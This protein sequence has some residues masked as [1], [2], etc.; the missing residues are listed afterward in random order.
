MCETPDEFC[1][2]GLRYTG[3]DE[4]FWSGPSPL[5]AQ[6]HRLQIAMIEAQLAASCE[7]VC[8]WS[9]R[10]GGVAPGPGTRVNAPDA[11]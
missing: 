11:S 7:V 9:R 2:F 10:A 3:P 8:R 4:S 1:I 6:G 5:P